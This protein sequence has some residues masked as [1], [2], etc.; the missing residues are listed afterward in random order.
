MKKDLEKE[1]KEKLENQKEELEKQLSKFARKD[2]NLEHDWDTK[3]PKMAQGSTGSNA[4]EEAADE[5]E[6]YANTL[7]VEHSLELRLRDIKLALEKIKKGA[8]GNCENCGQKI[9]EERLKVYP[10]ARLCLNCEK[11]N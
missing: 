1:L 5:V 4:L 11:K 6:Q 10:E 8:Y 7:P 9:N 3:Y 2:S